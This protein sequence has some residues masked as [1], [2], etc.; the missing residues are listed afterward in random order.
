M[1]R[2][3]KLLANKFTL[4]VDDEWLREIIKHW[5]YVESG[6]VF[7]LLDQESIEI[8]DDCQ[9]YLTKDDGEVIMDTYRCPDQKEFCLNCCGCPDHE[10]P[11]YE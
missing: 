7:Q 9:V 10:G 1:E 3:L 2:T 8:C 5:E 6:E 11:Y 4:V